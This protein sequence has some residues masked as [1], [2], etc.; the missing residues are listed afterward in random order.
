MF[1]VTAEAYLPIQLFEIHYSKYYLQYVH[2]SSQR[3]MAAYASI[4]ISL[5]ICGVAS[6]SNLLFPLEAEN[7]AA[8]RPPHPSQA[9]RA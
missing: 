6:S 4:F 7:V 1:V 2:L 9:A 3:N 5:F 8:S